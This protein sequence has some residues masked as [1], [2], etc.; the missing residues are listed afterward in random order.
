MPESPPSKA[1]A[2]FQSSDFRRYQLARVMAI[3]GA[4]AQIVTLL[5]GILSMNRVQL[6][7]AVA[8]PPWQTAFVNYEICDLIDTRTAL[9][10]RK[11]KWPLLPHP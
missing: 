10:V 9:Q 3:I 4:E 8:V 11:D 2:A 1:A 5:R 7:T 6:P